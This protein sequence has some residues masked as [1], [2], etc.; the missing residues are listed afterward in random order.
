ME[1]SPGMVSDKPTARLSRRVFVR[2][3]GRVS[4]ATVML[5]WLACER[6]SPREPSADGVGPDGGR[7]ELPPPP[8]CGPFLTATADFFQQFGG[9]ATV[10]GWVMPSLAADAR[11]R[12]EGLV[13]TPLQVDLAE[14]E[15]DGAQHR[16]VLKTML[17]VLGWR[18][19]ALFT[20]VPLR[21]LL[22]RAG[23]VRTAAKRV[24]F[25]GADGFENNLTLADIYE[26]PSDLFE[27]LVAFRINGERL[28]QALGFPFR[29]LLNDRYGFKN[30][31]W[32]ARIEV[33]AEDRETGQYQTNGYP[34]A[35][36]IEP[37]STTENLRLSERVAAG[38]V[39]ICGFA[40]SGRAGIA[41][42]ELALDGGGFVAAELSEAGATLVDHP[43]LA[44]AEQLADPARF[45]F[46]PRGVWARWQADL[47]LEP[48]MHRVAVRVIDRAGNA[49]DGAT[50]SL[51][52]AG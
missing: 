44:Q 32:L 40:L 37:T 33:T 42:V 16:T 4:A 45:G 11:M 17:C 13:G 51:E 39:Q 5:P 27:P 3:L 52:A 48:G 26:N 6:D 8:Q 14:L 18:S 24:R 21:V 43:Q 41:R 36:I 20:G 28:P 2:A 31:K 29:L 25:F 34:D 30:I 19:T 10:E 49:V 35:G 9:R 50:L 1:R 15:A 38:Q 22:D 23:I 47:A 7:R 46:P 12:I